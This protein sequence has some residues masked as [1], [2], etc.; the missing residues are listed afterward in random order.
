M[1]SGYSST[2]YR[3]VSIKLGI[4]L[5]KYLQLK[6]PSRKISLQHR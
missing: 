2:I 1:C 3:N 5:D 4:L 6:L